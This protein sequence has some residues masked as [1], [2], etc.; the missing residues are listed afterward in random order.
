MKITFVAVSVPALQQVRHFKEKYKE[1]CQKH[2]IEIIYFYVAG[3][4]QHYLLHPQLLT[5]PTCFLP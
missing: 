5:L 1:E 2:G 3:M 4:E